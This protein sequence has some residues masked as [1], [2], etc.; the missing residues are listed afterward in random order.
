MGKKFYPLQP[1]EYELVWADA[2]DQNVTYNIH[3]TANF[4][5]ETITG[6]ANRE[7]DDG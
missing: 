7:N 4:P 5:T 2:N 3:L 1:G 6:I